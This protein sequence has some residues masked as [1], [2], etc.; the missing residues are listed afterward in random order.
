MLSHTNFV[1]EKVFRFIN[2][3]KT[4]TIIKQT[5]FVINAQICIKLTDKICKR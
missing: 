5:Q 1:T 4:V 3:Q 2:F